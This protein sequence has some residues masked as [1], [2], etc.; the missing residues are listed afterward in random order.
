MAA[1]RCCAAVEAAAV[2]GNK[3]WRRAG[4]N[5]CVLWVHTE[6]VGRVG[7][8]G[9]RTSVRLT[10]G[11]GVCRRCARVNARVRL[12]PSGVCRWRLPWRT[13]RWRAVS[14]WCGRARR[15]RRVRAGRAGRTGAVGLVGRVGCARDVRGAL[16]R[17]G[18][19][20]ASGARGMCGRRGMLGV[21]RR[22]RRSSAC[23]AG[24]M[25][26]HGATG[27]GAPGRFHGLGH[28]YD[29]DNDASC[30]NS[31]DGRHTTRRSGRGG[32]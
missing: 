18:S 30:I 4:R 22:R 16:M 3:P 13:R 11:G 5:R 2:Q 29:D 32:A 10:L 24:V 7:T 19:S 25:T 12:H 28:G 9:A 27:V 26:E 23:V 1:W 31:G 8:A 14:V 20:G 17:S 15:A 6:R 21:C